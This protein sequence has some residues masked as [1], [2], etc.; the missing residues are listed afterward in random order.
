VAGPTLVSAQ[1]LDT[2][3][4]RV[5]WST[6][7]KLVDPTAAD[8]AL[9]PSNYA[10]AYLTTPA[11]TPVVTSVNAVSIGT[12]AVPTQ[13]DLTL[14]IDASPGKNY[15]L[16]ATN[17]VA[18]PPGDPTPGVPVVTFTAYTPPVPRGRRFDMYSMLQSKNRVDDITQ[19]LQ[20]LIACWQDP[21]TLLLA[22]IDT[23][24]E[25]V[26]YDL[27]PDSCL[28]ALL[29]GLGN[30]FA[31]D[32]TDTD[33]RRLLAVLVDIY[34]QRGTDVGIINAIRFFLGVEVTLEFYVRDDCWEIPVDRLGGPDITGQSVTADVLSNVFTLGATCMFEE[35]DPVQFTTSGTLPA[36]LALVTNYYVR[37]IVGSTFT[38][39]TAA[40]G[41]AIDI[42]DVGAG[43]HRVWCL[44][45][46]TAIL[47]PG[48]GDES[49]TYGFEIICPS[50]LTA[51]Q[52]AQMLSIVTFMRPVF[53]VLE[54]IWEA[55]VQ[56]WP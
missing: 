17:V 53:A 31:F 28:D 41:D 34:M 29:Y 42:T 55:G 6:D 30:P 1:A 46:G 51:D 4:V 32:M 39:A 37:A 16:T 12:T 56:T 8:D 33:K 7:V 18:N 40:G 23:F 15:Q 2:L 36:P 35:D 47:G 24:S 50:A 5:T 9:N 43:A 3:T 54:A 10:L 25:I 45:P 11:V 14:D 21:V 49:W 38:V 22:R 13:V 48:V 44:D 26:D 52:R 27:C 20:N 19:D